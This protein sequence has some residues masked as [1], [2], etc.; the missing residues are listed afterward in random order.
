M[1]EPTGDNVDAESAVLV[2]KERLSIIWLLPLI[3][4]LIGAWLAY[5]NYANLPINIT[6]HFPSRSRYRVGKSPRN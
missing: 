3:A 1:V 5:Q 4:L 2:Q 6:I